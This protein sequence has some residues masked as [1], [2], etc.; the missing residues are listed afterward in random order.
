MKKLL[1]IVLLVPTLA[2]TMISCDADMRTNLANLMGGFNSNVL[3]DGGLVKVNNANAE[4][5]A[6]AIQG[7]GTGTGAETIVDGGGGTGTTSSMGLSVSVDAGTKLLAPQTPDK[8][9]TL[10]T[11]LAAALNSPDQKKNLLADLSK[12]VNN[13]NGQIDAAKGTVTVFNLTLT[14]LAAGLPADSDLAKTFE[15]LQL[16]VI[17]DGD[18]VTQGDLLTLQLMT[19]LISNTI[20]KLNELSEGD[21][22]SVDGVLLSAHQDDVLAIVGDALFA[23]KVAEQISGSSSLN[24][25]GDIDFGSILGKSVK[26]RDIPL[27]DAADF[28]DVINPIAQKIVSLLGVT[29]SGG[30]YSYS[31]A[32]YSSFLLNQMVYRTAI[33]QALS[34]IRMGSLIDYDG[35]PSL[36]SSTIIKYILSVAITEHEG[37]RAYWTDTYGDG[38]TPT[39]NEL[40]E[41]YLNANKP[42]ASGTLKVSDKI[43]VPEIVGFDYQDWPEYMKTKKIGGVA[44]DD[45]KAYHKAILENIQTIND[46]GGI[47]LLA[48]MLNDFLAG[49][50]DFV[51]EGFDKVY[52]DLLTE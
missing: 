4:A 40:I 26:N 17:K 19:D 34:M 21:L 14:A 16:P 25:F 12:P 27:T 29:E 8:Q 46:A 6:T 33:E 31:D 3:I 28:I 13:D 41:A 30:T 22:D 32:K 36:G 43:V 7:I 10:K 11:D 5:A 48:D 39:A 52:S 9:K 42:L 47:D 24:V 18:T 2:L 44:A 15:K 1:V 49:T 37:F 45:G 38:D 23:A 50:G 35:L 20:N 51:G